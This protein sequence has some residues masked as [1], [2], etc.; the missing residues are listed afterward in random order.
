MKTYKSIR[1]SSTVIHD[2]GEK[3]EK[4]KNKNDN[5]ILMHERD[6][7]VMGTYICIY[8]CVRA[9]VNYDDGWCNYTYLY[10]CVCV[11]LWVPGGK[12]AD[13]DGQEYGVMKVTNGIWSSLYV[14]FV[15]IFLFFLIIIIII[16]ISRIVFHGV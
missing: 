4:I 3:D 9:P 12:D 10:V 5:S 2:G 8:T 14:D 15:F 16:V 1:C 13:N 7:P 11:C 6:R